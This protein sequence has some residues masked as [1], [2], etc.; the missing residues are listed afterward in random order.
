MLAVGCL[1]PLMGMAVLGFGVGAI[2]GA[3]AGLWA[4]GA[5]FLL[6]CAG[7]AMLLWGFERVRGRFGA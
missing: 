5:G 7:M 4:G 1:L 2:W 3:R 6:G